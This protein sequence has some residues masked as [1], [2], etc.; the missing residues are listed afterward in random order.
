MTITIYD[1]TISVVN[2]KFI[3]EVFF[4]YRVSFFFVIL[5]IHIE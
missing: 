4:L 5:Q 2:K 1:K 3:A